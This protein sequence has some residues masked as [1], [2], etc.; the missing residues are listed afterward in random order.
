M[1][2]RRTQAKKSI[3]KSS[4]QIQKVIVRY[5]DIR[6]YQLGGISRF[7]NEIVHIIE[8]LFGIQNATTL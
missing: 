6:E 8:G 1:R 2:Q 3:G 5:F 7:R 4:Y